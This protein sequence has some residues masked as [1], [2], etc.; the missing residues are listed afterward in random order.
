MSDGRVCPHGLVV[1]DQNR[2]GEN[3]VVSRYLWMGVPETTTLDA[4]P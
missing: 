3:D 1:A 2:F 4:R